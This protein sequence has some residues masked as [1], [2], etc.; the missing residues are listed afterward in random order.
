MSGYRQ[1]KPISTWQAEIAVGKRPEDIDLLAYLPPFMAAYRELAAALRA[2]EPEFHL[3]W[4]GA[5]RVLVN[6]FVLTADD[7]GLKRYESLL[8]LLPASG[9]TVEAR[10]V[11]ILAALMRHPP[12][13]MTWLRAWLDGLCGEGMHRENV[14]DYTLSLWLDGSALSNVHLTAQE[15]IL[16]LNPI[17]PVNLTWI[18][19]VEMPPVERPLHVGGRMGAHAR[20]GTAEKPDV[21]DYRSTVYLGGRAASQGA[22]GAAERPDTP[23]FRQTVYAGGKAGAA[24]VLRGRENLTAPT[25]TG[26]LRAG[27]RYASGVRFADGGRVRLRGCAYTVMTAK[28]EE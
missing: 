19:R 18:I 20:L 2:E 7:F 10:R 22:L 15:I 14:E 28:G 23:D 1:E 16:L 3:L 12:Y 4:R 8:H 11:R 25:M 9:D 5:H 13:T 24:S 26:R 21:F 27:G 6:Q 17:L